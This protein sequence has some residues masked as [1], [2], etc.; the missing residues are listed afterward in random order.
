KETNSVVTIG[1]FDGVHIGHRKIIETLLNIS[2]EKKL[3]NFVI[4]FDP[5]PRNIVTENFKNSVLTSIDEKIELL[6]KLGI[7]NLLIVNFT[8]E[9]SQLSSEDF[10]KDYLIEKLNTKHVIAGINHKIGKG[11]NTDEAILQE[12]GKNLGFDVS[13]VEPV[14]FDDDMVSS[15]KIRNEILLGN[16]ELVGKFLDRNYFIFGKAV[17]GVSRGKK[18]GYPTANIQ[19]DDKHKLIPNNGV[20]IVSCELNYKKYFGIM[21]I[22]LRPTFA[23]TEEKVIEVHLFD[24]NENIY[25]QKIKIELLNYIRKE[26]TFP[27][28]AELIEQIK[29]DIDTAKIF[30]AETQRRRGNNNE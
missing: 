27:N 3:S 15:T 16:W 12:L 20:Y 2:R 26:K 4:T 17:E 14:I 19:P 21:N 8:K 13:V 6:G 24:F 22:G 5:H 7:E 11:R 18:L 23:D 28:T 1:T 30:T 9:F 29:K 10:I 25:G